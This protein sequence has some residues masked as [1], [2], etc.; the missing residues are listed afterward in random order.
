MIKNCLFP[1]KENLTTSTVMKAI[2]KLETAGLIST[3]YVEGRPYL[4]LPTWDHHQTIRAHK[5]KYPKPSEA[6]N[7]SSEIICMQTNTD[8]P[9]IQSN[10]NPNP[11]PISTSSLVPSDSVIALPLN[12]GTERAIS[13][14]EVDHWQSLYPAVDVMQEL[15]KMVGWCEGHPNRKKT[16]R[17][18]G[19]F[20]TGWLAKEQDKGKPARTEPK[21]ETPPSS[22]NRDEFFDKALR[23][24]EKMMREL[25]EK[26]LND[27]DGTD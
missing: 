15:R 12:D 8:D 25:N 6:D 19:A 10:P 11:N 27:A 14:E 16:K 23:R 5:S 18:V 1:L 9:V 21:Q 3:Y 7:Q 4:S 13:Q 22:F 17:G 24:S 2:E 20:I 26:R